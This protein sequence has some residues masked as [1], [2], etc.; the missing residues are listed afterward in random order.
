MAKVI[1][2]LNVVAWSGF[3]AF[4]FLA[5][6]GDPSGG[7]MMMAL[8]LAALGA[9]LGLWAWFWIVR[10]SE[11]IGYAKLANRARIEEEETA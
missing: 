3:W 2:I 11:D 1:A 7:Q 5:L 10:H 8:V 4:G 6:S 9:G